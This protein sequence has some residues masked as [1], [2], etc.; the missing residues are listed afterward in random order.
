MAILDSNRLDDKLTFMEAIRS[1][2][3][4]SDLP[5][6]PSRKLRDAIFRILTGSNSLE[7]AMASYQLLID[8]DKHYPRIYFRS[9]DNAKTKPKSFSAL[10]SELVVVKE[11]WSPF[12]VGSESCHSVAEGK[13]DTSR[14]CTLIEEISQAVRSRSSQLLLKPAENMLLFQYLVRVLETDFLPRHTLYKGTLEWVLLRES[15]LS[16]LLVSRR[17]NF[18]S[19]VRDCICIISERCHHHKET[20]IKDQKDAMA[21]SGS[22]EIAQDCDIP[23]AFAA[24]ELEKQACYAVQRFFVLVM[25]LD[26]IRKEADQHA[27]TS[28]VDGVRTPVLE[29]ILDELTYA[30]DCISPLLEVFSDPRWKLEIILQYFSKYCPKSSIRTRRSADTPKDTTFEDILGYFS[31][32]VRT[33]AIIRKVAS[34]EALLLLAHLF[35]AYLSLHRDQKYASTIAEKVGSGT[36]SQICDGLISA[37]QNIGKVDQNLELMAFEK[38]AL[39]TAVTIASQP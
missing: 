8:L 2:C 20:S 34:K 38:E 35:Q 23:L 31:S 24:I 27:L 25:E 12:C 15:L 28:R 17:V 21:L 19:M 14:F 7:L 29:I 3:L 32:A 4:N 39:F 37:F 22:T 10:D 18:K 26:L 6:P 1:A 33:N 16:M 30:K 13:V 5:T 11:G 36:L 9:P